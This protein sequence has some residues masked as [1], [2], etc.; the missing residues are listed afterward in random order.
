MP[1][2]RGKRMPKWPW[3]FLSVVIIAVVVFI[4]LWATDVIL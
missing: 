3:L 1:R 4:V 2:A